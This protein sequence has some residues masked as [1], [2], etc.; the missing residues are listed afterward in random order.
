MSCRQLDQLLSMRSEHCIVDLDQCAHALRAV[1]RDLELLRTVGG[2]DLKLDPQYSRRHLGLL[3]VLDVARVGRSR[4]QCNARK[5]G[6]H[7]LEKLQPLACEIG[8]NGG[9]S[10]DVAAWS[11]QARYYARRGG[12]ERRDKD[13]GHCVRGI[14]RRKHHRRARG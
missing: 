7:L 9:Q 1:E 2:H 5:R 10:G 13:D 3:N 4:K 11:R 12:I 6:Q 8:K 14:A